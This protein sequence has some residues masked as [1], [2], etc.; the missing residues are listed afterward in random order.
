MIGIDCGQRG[1]LI[2]LQLVPRA[3]IAPFMTGAK[4]NDF[5]N[6]ALGNSGFGVV[7]GPG[8]PM[9][10]QQARAGIDNEMSDIGGFRLRRHRHEDPACL[11]NGKHQHDGIGVVGRAIGDAVAGSD[12]ETNKS[13]SEARAFPRQIGKCI[14]PVGFGVDR[15]EQIAASFRNVQVR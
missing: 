10:K 15:C 2:A 8:M 6:A 5:R 13:S 9:N 11:P 4:S 1:L 7:E 14:M 12:A 3:Q